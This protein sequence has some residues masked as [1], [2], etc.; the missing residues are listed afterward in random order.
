MTTDNVSDIVSRVAA[1][2]PETQYA[3]VLAVGVTLTVCSRAAYP[4]NG[5]AGDLKQ[6]VAFNE[7][8]HRV[9]GYLRRNTTDEWTLQTFVASLM[10]I[11]ANS[12]VT[13]QLAWALKP[14]TD[15]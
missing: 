4:M 7:L 14:A 8:Q 2:S 10:E 6:L 1:R 3:W 12:G 9:F 13:A 5:S 15:G 11:A